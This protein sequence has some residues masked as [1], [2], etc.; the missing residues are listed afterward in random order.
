MPEDV[1][2]DSVGP[3]T[4]VHIEVAVQLGHRDG[5]R[6]DRKQPSYAL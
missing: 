2:T 6:V 3:L 1:R 5:F 4:R